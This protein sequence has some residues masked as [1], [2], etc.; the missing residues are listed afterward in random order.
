I[1][2]FLR[3]R[4]TKL[5]L[6]IQHVSLMFL[7]IML[8][9]WIYYSF[10]FNSIVGYGKS[11]YAAIMSE[12]LLAPPAIYD[13]YPL[14]SIFLNTL[15]VSLIIML[16]ICGFLFLTTVRNSKRSLVMGY[17]VALVAT[18]AVGLTFRFVYILPHRIFVFLEA[19]ALV[20][21]AAAGIR[22]AGLDGFKKRFSAARAFLLSL[23]V[24]M[25]FFFSSSST[26]AGFE[27]SQFIGDQPYVKLYETEYE[28]SSA[29]WIGS[30]LPVE[31]GQLIYTAWSFSGFSKMYILSGLGTDDVDMERIPLMNANDADIDLIESNSTVIFSTF[32]MEIGFSLG[33]AVAGRFGQ[34]VLT[35]FDPE[36][37][38]DFAVLDRFYDNGQIIAFQRNG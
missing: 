37:L 20:F 3:L 34:G 11:Y 15:G 1:E 12:S 6:S 23:L 17:T 8:G 27:T 13:T 30:N 14:T 32:D 36:V 31:D 4:G 33:Q 5:R 18:A 10:L 29:E 9:H 28:R 16:S 19:F 2:G 25:I 22:F 38:A 26:I 7:A 21:L 35:K 24:V